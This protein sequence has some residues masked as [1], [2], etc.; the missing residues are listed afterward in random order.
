MDGSEGKI[1]P[2]AKTLVMLSLLAVLAV[3]CA[4][5]PDDVQPVDPNAAAPVRFRERAQRNAQAVAEAAAGA[6]PASVNAA[7]WGFDP[8]DS[9]AALQAAIDSRAARVLV[10]DMGSPWIIRPVRLAGD[11]EIVLEDGVVIEAKKGEFRKRTDALFEA[12]AVSNLTLSGSGAVLRMHRDD[13]R[14]PPYERSEHRHALSLRSCSNVVV[15]GLRIE[16]SGGDGIYLGRS[17]KRGAPGY[18][19]HIE[20]RDVVLADNYRQGISVVSVKGLLV[21][22]TVMAR[23]RGTPPAAGI[24]FEPNHADELVQDIVLRGCRIESNAGAGLQVY[25]NELTAESEPVSIRVDD[26]RIRGNRLQVWITPGGGA[27]SGEIRFGHCD[28]GWLRRV[29]RAAGLSVKL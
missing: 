17:R 9:T 21:E 7:W 24:D 20:I 25:L 5:S 22:R 2:M 1:A 23:T 3:S 18:G 10:P 4:G 16:S 12:D 27:P 29:R 14:R 28:I 26:T 15:Q 6:R 19:E 13:Y 8:A 11:Q